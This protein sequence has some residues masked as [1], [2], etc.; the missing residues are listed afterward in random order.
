MNQRNG[1]RKRTQ[2]R[3]SPLN[4]SSGLK[5]GDWSLQSSNN[6]APLLKGSNRSFRRPSTIK[7]FV[8][9]VNAVATSVLNGQGNI[10]VARAFSALARTVAQA[11]NVEMTKARIAK[12]SPDMALSDDVFEEGQ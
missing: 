4:E 7:E 9:Q 12:Q 10:E 5:R 6:Y 1:G 2:K 11:M 8:S 3:G